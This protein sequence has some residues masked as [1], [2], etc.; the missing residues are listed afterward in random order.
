MAL[1][2]EGAA[3]EW[4]IPRIRDR[5]RR[6]HGLVH[7]LSRQ[8]VR[9][10]PGL[11][12]FS[13]T[14]ADPD[15]PLAAQRWDLDNDGEFDDAA[16]ETTT[17][18]FGKA[19]AQVRL[20]VTDSRRRGHGVGHGDRDR[21]AADRPAP[22]L[23]FGV[24]VRR[25][26]PFT[27]RVKL[28]AVRAPS[29]ASVTVR[30][31]EAGCRTGTCG[32][33]AASKCG[34]ARARGT[35]KLRFRRLERPYRPGTKIVVSATKLGFIK[36]QTWTIRR[37][38]SPLHREQCLYPRCDSGDRHARSH[39]SPGGRAASDCG[40]CRPLRGVVRRCPERPRRGPQRR[41]DPGQS[42]PVVEP[43]PVLA[44]GPNAP[45]LPRLRKPP[46][47]KLAAPAQAPGRPRPRLSP[48]PAPA[49]SAS[50]Q[51]EP[52]SQSEAPSP[53]PRHRRLPRRSQPAQLL[54]SRRRSRNP[55]STYDSGG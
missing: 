5:E 39:E 24:G 36:Q 55:K 3:A 1:R 12:R 51:P 41:A 13:S 2:I 33:R 27:T 31:V 52:E 25:I 54:L 17:R 47:P 9:G 26:S 48:A 40:L 18:A 7:V 38:R 45:G 14:S 20:Q 21:T 4:A 53:R 44:L 46:A 42:A 34:S 28:L 11:D 29:G 50:P 23:E 37:R 43:E 32:E 30:C 49:P 16:G 8:R 10:R 19:G 22:A 35:R 15:G 6:T